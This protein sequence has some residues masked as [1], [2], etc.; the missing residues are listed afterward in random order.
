MMRPAPFSYSRASSVPA[1]VAACEAGGVYL[2]GGQA[3]LHSMKM[4]T[5]VPSAVVDVSGLSELH[6]IETVSSS[7]LRI[8]AL[9]TV[10]DMAASPVIATHAPWLAQ[11]ARLVGDPQVRHRATVGGNVAWADPRAN[12]LIALAASR[13][14]AE[15]KFGG[16][17]RHLHAEAIAT[18][19]RQNGLGSGLLLGFDVPLRAGSHGAYV[20]IARQPQD[21]ALVSVGVVVHGDPVVGASVIFGGIGS[22]PVRATGLERALVGCERAALGEL[23]VSRVMSALPVVPVEDQH[24]PPSYRAH[25]ARIAMR[26]AL[27]QLAS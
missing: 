4:R 21:L 22:T 27:E 16:V 17:T 18:G 13:A 15:I 25:V 19:F 7:M 24:G 10:S 26:R 11:A 23:D 3:L 5:A 6:R 14:V 12:L 20:E 2:A 9:T 1:A 8:G